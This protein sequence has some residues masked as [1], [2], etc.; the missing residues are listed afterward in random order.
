MRGTGVAAGQRQARDRGDRGQRFAAEAER[1]HTFEV[2]E[3]GDF[4]GGVAGQRQREFILGDAA[5]VVGNAD[6]FD[7]AFLQLNLDRLAAGVEGVFEQFLENGG[8]SFDHFASGNLADQQVGEAGDGRHRRIIPECS[9]GGQGRALPQR[10]TLVPPSGRSSPLRR[11][12]R[13]GYE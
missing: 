6:Q 3:R 13:T 10:S 8:G 12:F 2:V 4:R 7:A 11:R 9:G 1:G 5:A